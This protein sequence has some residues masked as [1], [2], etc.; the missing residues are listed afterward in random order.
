MSVLTTTVIERDHAI[1]RPGDDSNGMG[2]ETGRMPYSHTADRALAAAE[3]SEPELTSTL[4]FRRTLGHFASGVAVVTGVVDD[5]PIGMSVS[6][7]LRFAPCTRSISPLPSSKRSRNA[8][9]STPR[10]STT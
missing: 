3:D 10:M 5:L 8:T 6:S 4:Q 9:A 1:T 2:S 7:W